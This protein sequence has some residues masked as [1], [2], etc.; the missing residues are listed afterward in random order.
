MEKSSS[1]KIM[2]A[3]RMIGNDHN[4]GNYDYL[5]FFQTSFFYWIL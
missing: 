2:V 5:Y 3:T 1:G 4:N